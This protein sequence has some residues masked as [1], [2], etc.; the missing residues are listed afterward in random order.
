MVPDIRLL[1]A[2]SLPLSGSVASSM[3]GTEAAY[4]DAFFM[5]GRLS[6]RTYDLGSTLFPLPLLP[7]PPLTFPKLEAIGRRRGWRENVGCGKAG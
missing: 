7:L 6:G 4:V 2:V 3:G 5:V 1:L